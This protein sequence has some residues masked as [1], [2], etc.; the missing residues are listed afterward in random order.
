[1]LERIGGHPLL[2]AWS[3]SSDAAIL[4]IEGKGQQAVV[5][6]EQAFAEKLRVLG[7]DSYDGACEAMNKGNAL[8]FAGRYE[9]ALE[10]TRTSVDMLTRAVGPEHPMVAVGMSN[11]GESLLF[12]RRYPEARLA[13]ERAFGI[14]QR[15]AADPI[16]LAVAQVGIGLSRLGE[17]APALAAPPLEEALRVR[18]AKQTN[19]VH[20]GEVRFALARALW[21]TPAS[22]ARARELA[23]VA[24]KD[25]ERDTPTGA[26][27]ATVEQIDAWQRAPTSE[28]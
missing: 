16:F 8:E 22:R 28:L 9:E 11:Q 2:H 20:M 7:P 15:M 24:R 6:S 27:L 10:A 19:A 12:L 13:Y 4:M 17:R 14:W 3:L 18:A 26:S 1:M 21:A 23:R 25:L 5:A